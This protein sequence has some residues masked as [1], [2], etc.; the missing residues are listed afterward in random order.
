MGAIHQPITL[1]THVLTRDLAMSAASFDR[2]WVQFGSKFPRTIASA[3]L[4]T[5]L[6]LT[7]YHQ[8]ISEL[9]MA[10]W[11]QPEHSQGLV[12]A[13][14]AL[15][16]AWL[17]RQSMET[18]AARHELR[19]LILIALGC[20]T[21]LFGLLAAGMYISQLS[22]VVILAGLVWTFWGSARLKSLAMPILLLFT[23]IPLPGVLYGTLS[24]P[25]Q[26]LTSR[27]A[28]AIADAIGVTVYREG[29]VIH[30]A[31]ISLGVWEACNGLN[32]LSALIVGA[33][34]L[35][36]TLC[37]RT[38]TRVLICLSA[39]PVAITANVV[40]VSATAILSDW[41]PIYAMGFYHGFSGWIV[42]LIGVGSLYVIALGFRRWIER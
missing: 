2:P 24:R 1:E 26:L 33:V 25:L 41:R 29:N 15:V 36:F 39:V 31:S 17:Q 6:L 18:T 40:R 14:F 7:I 32:S 9:F 11:S 12:I 37:R 27:I 38:L 4:I 5:C 35:S 22:L 42:F 16:M 34:L 28:C 21:H 10:W 8:A 23:A 3:T 30:L 20:F 19:G 13:P